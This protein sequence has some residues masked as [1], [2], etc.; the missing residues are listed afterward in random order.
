MPANWDASA[1]IQHMQQQHEAQQQ[2]QQAEVQA[3]NDDGKVAAQYVH[4]M[5]G[6]HAGEAAQIQ[7]VR[8]ASRL[9]CTIDD[10]W[11][12]GLVNTTQKNT[13]RVPHMV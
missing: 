9:S 13:H 11:I 10:V 5:A 8:Q 2:R 3:Q 6:S 1:H 4:D 7:Q 12:P